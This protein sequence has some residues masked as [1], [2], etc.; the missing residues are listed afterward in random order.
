MSFVRW[1]LSHPHAVV[2]A[3]G[4]VTVLGAVG[5][6]VTP[7]DLFPDTA[8][9][10]V[11]VLAVWP[12]ATARDVDDGVTKLL[13][14]E[15]A[16]LDGLERIRSSS[17]DEVAALSVEFAYHRDAGVA[18][19]DVRNAV[20]AVGGRLPE[21][22][23]E[24][25]LHRID[26]ASRPVM[27][28]SL[29]WRPGT[30]RGLGDLRLWARE[31]LGRRLLA[32]PR[33]ARVEFFG[34]RRL[35]VAVD[36]D[37]HRLAAHGL[38]LAHVAA[39]LRA[40]NLRLPGGSLIARGR[41]LVLRTSLEAESPAALEEIVLRAAPDG[42]VRL[43]DVARVRL[44]EPPRRSFYRGD[45]R[46]TLAVALFRAPAQ[47][48]AE[49][50]AAGRR[51]LDETARARPELVWS[52]TEDQLPLIELNRKGMLESLAQAGLLT[53]AVIAFFLGR[54]RTALVASAAIPLS[55]LAAFALLWASPMTINMVTLS[56]LIISVGMVVDASV[57]VLENVQ[58]LRDEGETDLG[59][60]ALAGAAEVAAPVTAGMLTT[61]FVVL[62]LLFTGGYTQQIM[63]PLNFV[64]SATLAASLVVA[65][66]VVPLAARRFLRGAGGRPTGGVERV[67]DRAGTGLVKGLAAVYRGLLERALAHRVL[68]L[69]LAGL[70]CVGSAALLAPLVG[71]ELMPPMDTGTVIVEVETAPEAP[72]AE[73][74]AVAARVEALVRATP[75]VEA[76]SLVAGSDPGAPRFAGGAATE[77][78]M[79]LTV[80]L[81]DRM[82]RDRTIWEIMD[83]WRAGLLRC[84]GVR[85]FAVKEYGATPL[86]TTRAPLDI[87]VTGPSAARLEEAARA[88][89]KRIATIPGMV[90]LRRSWTRDRMVQVLE[91]E[92][93]AAALEGLS[94]AELGRN[95]A[96]A[97]RGL[98]AG[99]LALEDL[100][101]LPVTVRLAPGQREEAE[102]VLDL[103]LGA[104]TAVPLRAMARLV[105]E[106][107]R[108][109]ITRER[110]EESLNLTAANRDVTIGALA[111]TVAR[112]LAELPLPA[113]VAVHVGG[114]FENLEDSRGRMA[115]GVALGLV[116][117]YGLLVLLFGSFR[118]PLTV[119]SAIPVAAASSLW[120]LFLFDKPLCMPAMMGFILLGGTIVNN[121][122]LLLDFVLE[123]R[124]RGADRREALLESVRLRLRPIL[125]TTVSTVLGLMPFLL[126]SAV[127][128][129]RMSPL[130]IVSA[131]GLALGTLSTLVVTPVAY[132]VV[133]DLFG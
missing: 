83:G 7:A 36:V 40:Q 5:L 92:G 63:R 23:Q 12:G 60:A 32:D 38:S 82:R 78:S 64:I 16:S 98:P 21:G 122:I 72:S 79:R 3:A 94:P 42:I 67:L 124:S 52:I 33:I 35:E 111:P 130:G 54:W 50:I 112:A 109:L 68:T 6:V 125:M 58:R 116:L 90:D 110:L 13:E 133:E 107:D 69:A 106:V 10:Q 56:G 99:R 127:G 41:E 30:P 80:T 93:E 18:L 39:S 46:E 49:A 4:L 62:P 120:G 24:P 57:V 66:A 65:L 108:P 95:V 74:E 86:S 77:Q 117:L 47:A 15:F 100:D 73:I 9:P 25:T 22:L 123:R 70:F 53:F 119:L 115:R 103:A 1:A 129:E 76:L 126:E 43:R 11:L 31:E 55:F 101:D 34:G 26:D 44:A 20:A 71:F 121:S 8:P 105:P 81:V 132:T 45:G 48:A 104:E 27:V 2:V 61:V 128:L 91:P 118:H 29:G 113:G 37:R 87:L 85:R 97:L 96:A 114:S 59:R 89:E 88:I 28:A 131:V 14:R 75:G 102:G 51:I 19:V 84:P 17:R